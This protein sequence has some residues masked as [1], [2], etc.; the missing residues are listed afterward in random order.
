MHYVYNTFKL[1]Y[2]VTRLRSTYIY[3]RYNILGIVYYMDTMGIHTIMG[4]YTVY[5]QN[6]LD[7]NAVLLLYKV[8][9]TIPSVYSSN[10]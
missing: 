7:M 2:I 5:A 6:K 9:L 4:Y 1:T 3:I 10:H 8:K